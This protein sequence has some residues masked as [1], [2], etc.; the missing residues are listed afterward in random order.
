[1]REITSMLEEK[2]LRVK[3]LG[4]KF[5]LVGS[6]ATAATTTQ[7]TESEKNLKF[8]KISKDINSMALEKECDMIILHESKLEPSI[9]ELLEKCDVIRK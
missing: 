9:I 5:E 7:M 6:T 2:I 8:R 4:W 1:M 3:E